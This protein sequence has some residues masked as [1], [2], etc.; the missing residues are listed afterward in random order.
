M[1]KYSEL[2]INYRFFIDYIKCKQNWRDLKILD[3]GCKRGEIVSILRSAGCDCR[4]IDPQLRCDIPLSGLYRLPRSGIYPFEDGFFDIVISN[5]LFEHINDIDT[6]I[7][8]MDRVLK[9]GGIMYHHFPT[10]ETLRDPHLKPYFFNVCIRLDMVPT[11]LLR[12]CLLL[13]IYFFE[14]DYNKN[15]ISLTQWINDKLLHMSTRCFYRSY[16]TITAKFSSQYTVKNNEIGY[17]RY[18]I[19]RLDPSWKKD[20]ASLILRLPHRLVVFVFRRLSFSA[21]E[22]Q[23]NN[24]RRS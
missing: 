9:H 23:K 17:I 11:D 12:K 22:L 24:Q 8:Q 19:L 14:Q 13:F 1:H 15:R 21:V 3:V 6:A 5:Q 20:L 2:N 18:R 10:S 4:G 7:A 16:K